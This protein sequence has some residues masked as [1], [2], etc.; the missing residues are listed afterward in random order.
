VRG[1]KNEIKTQEK[2]KQK[3]DTPDILLLHKL[4]K[5]GYTK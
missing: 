4:K 3:E 1:E 2:P 5:E